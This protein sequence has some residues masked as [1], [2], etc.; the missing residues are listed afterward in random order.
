MQDD[1]YMSRKAVIIPPRRDDG[2]D[3]LRV[4][5]CSDIFY[6]GTLGYKQ[7]GKYKDSLV[8]EYNAGNTTAKYYCCD[9]EN[10]DA[11]ECR[12]SYWLVLFGQPEV[13]TDNSRVGL[14]DVENRLAM[15][16]LHKISWLNDIFFQKTNK[17]KNKLK[18]SIR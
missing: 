5:N 6:L 12:D 3:I 15:H 2:P 7:N 18:K 8:Y 17:L 10:E 11:T 16:S 1:F 13:G 9:L 4:D 14:S